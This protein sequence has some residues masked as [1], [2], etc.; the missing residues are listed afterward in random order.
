MPWENSSRNY[1]VTSLESFPSLSMHLIPEIRTP[2]RLWLRLSFFF[3]SC[4][5]CSLASR[6]RRLSL[7]LAH[8]GWLRAWMGV[9]ESGFKGWRWRKTGRA[10]LERREKINAQTLSR[11][12]YTSW[13]RNS[14]LEK[15]IQS[16][17]Y[18]AVSWKWGQSTFTEIRKLLEWLVAKSVDLRDNNS[19][20]TML[21]ST[22]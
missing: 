11:L 20:L 6:F 13:D 7:F 9:F 15:L 14:R 18:Y 5:F 10:S 19:R 2:L 1:R 17:D 3:F 21:K 16:T 12:I 8:G 22:E 4:P